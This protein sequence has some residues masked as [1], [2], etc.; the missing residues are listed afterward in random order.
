M[1]EKRENGLEDVER[2]VEVEDDAVEYS[3]LMSRPMSLYSL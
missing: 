1:G 2:E 3:E